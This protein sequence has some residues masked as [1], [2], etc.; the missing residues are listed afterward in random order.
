LPIFANLKRHQDSTKDFLKQK[1][2][3]GYYVSIILKDL[4]K[5]PIPQLVYNQMWLILLLDDC[6]IN[7]NAK[8]I[9]QTLYLTILG[10]IETCN[11][12]EITHILHS[13]NNFVKD[14]MN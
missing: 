12:S 2:N 11:F 14:V 10:K 1:S 13:G 3:C 7:N 5:F 4:N 6:H 9:R 8:L